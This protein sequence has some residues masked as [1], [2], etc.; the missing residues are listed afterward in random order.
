MRDSDKGMWWCHK[1]ASGLCYVA[2]QGDVRRK[3][4]EDVEDPVETDAAIDV[5]E[6]G[7]KPAAEW[8][9]APPFVTFGALYFLS[10]IHI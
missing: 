1:W 8:V 2:K 9:E 3:T 6:C 7:D 10:L 5:E 4:W